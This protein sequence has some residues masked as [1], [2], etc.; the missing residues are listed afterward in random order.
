MRS[1][2]R[3]LAGALLLA[4][5]GAPAT[6]ADA[7]KPP[8]IDPAA[9]AA[10]QRMGTFLR[11][12]QALE[13]QS[14]TTTD[15][16]L[17]SGQKVEYQGTVDLKARRPNRLAVDVRSDRRNERIFYDGTTFTVFQPTVGYYASFAAPPTLGELVDVL[18]QKYGVDLPLAD[19]FR[20]GTNEGQLAQIRGAT[21]VGTSTVKGSACSHYAFHQ[22]DVD[23]E[24]WIQ[25][26][27]QPLP[28]KL[29]ITTT[30]EKSQPQHTSVLSWNLSP[31]LEDQMFVFTPPP[32]SQRIEFDVTKAGAATR[33]IKGGTP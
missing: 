13:V 23:W 8:A 21:L 14:E 2:G 31:N 7:P 6:W 11:G 30:T 32:G 10:L 4:G 1:P 22:A 19:L 29:V 26:G 18:E 25:D 27:A 9:I 17:P 16:V 20:L 12:L 3:A 5:L 33:S 28:R 24:L 15:D